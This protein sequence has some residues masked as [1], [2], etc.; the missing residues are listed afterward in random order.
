MLLEWCCISLVMLSHANATSDA[1][2]FADAEAGKVGSDNGEVNRKMQV[3]KK[4]GEKH[5]EA[6]LVPFSRTAVLQ[7]QWMLSCC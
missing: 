4:E 1:Q 6:L 3:E 7:K 2:K 5:F